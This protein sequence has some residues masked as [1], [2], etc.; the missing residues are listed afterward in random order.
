[1]SATLEKDA[2]KGGEFI[3]RETQADEIFIPEE[4]SEEQKMMAQACDDFIEKEIT[5]VVERMDKMEE[6]LMPSLMDKAGELG[7]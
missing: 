7:L 4:F 2:I 3:I 6:G 5:P 1:M